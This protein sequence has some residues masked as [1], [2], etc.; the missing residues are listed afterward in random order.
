MN[1]I[2]PTFSNSEKNDLAHSG[3][4]FLWA[5]PIMTPSVLCVHMCQFMH[6]IIVGFIPNIVYEIAVTDDQNDGITL[7]QP[8]GGTV[9]Y[10]IGADY[11]EVFAPRRV[12]TLL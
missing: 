4:V 1:C 8:A 3:G 10:E 9:S 5:K 12:G 7:V 2:W 11:E 6:L